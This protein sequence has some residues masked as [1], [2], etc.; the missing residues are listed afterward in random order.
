MGA[1]LNF[2]DHFSKH[3]DVY[4]KYRPGYPEQLYS[5]LASQVTSHDIALDCAT[6]NG[7]AALGLAPYFNEV[8]ATD[9]SQ[10]QLDRAF[11]HPKIKYRLAMAEKL[12]VPDASVDLLTIASGAHWFDLEQFYTEAKRVLRKDAVIA[13][14][15]YHGWSSTSG[16]DRILHALE[17]NVVGDY[18]PKP[19]QKDIGTYYADMPFPF[20]EIVVPSFKMPLLVNRDWVIGYLRSWSATQRY[21][22]ANKSDPTQLIAKEL[23]E[24]FSEPNKTVDLAFKLIARA[25]RVK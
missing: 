6:G 17:Q 21:I 2:N 13:L 7:Q 11:P 22:E 10:A 1:T 5:F 12:P 23:D 18:W 14:W 24:L 20:D 25:G 15:V 4:V 3:A 19:L 16:L 8:I 9:A